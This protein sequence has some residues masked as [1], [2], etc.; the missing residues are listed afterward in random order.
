M[1]KG[2]LILIVLA[3]LFV[4]LLPTFSQAREPITISGKVTDG[5]GHSVDSALIAIPA[6]SESTTTDDRGA[7]RLLV[8]SK[9]RSG[10]EV[11]IRASRKG[12]DYASRPVRLRP[13][14][15]LRINFRL[16]EAR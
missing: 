16:S 6:L 9:V 14:A 12:F 1:V 5:R 11:V 8:R 13:G 4:T 2:K 15:R 3:C 7:Y 10:E